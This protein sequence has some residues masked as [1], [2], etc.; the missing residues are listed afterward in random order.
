MHC[1]HTQKRQLEAQVQASSLLFRLSTIFSLPTHYSLAKQTLWTYVTHRTEFCHWFWGEHVKSNT[2]SQTIYSRHS[3]SD[4]EFKISPFLQLGWYRLKLHVFVIC[5]PRLKIWVEP[6]ILH[7]LRDWEKMTISGK[8]CS[9]KIIIQ[10]G[11][12]T[13]WLDG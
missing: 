6:G 5:V 7:L 3:S 2:A 11:C 13:E 8:H 9:K 12:P 10:P 1:F 4:L